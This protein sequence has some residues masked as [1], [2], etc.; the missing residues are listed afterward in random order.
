MANTEIASLSTTLGYQTLGSGLNQHQAS[1]QPY[2]VHPLEI[3][4]HA[5]I[6]GGHLAQT[7]G[8]VALIT[9]CLSKY[10]ELR[11]RCVNSNTITDNV[12]WLLFIF[13]FG[14][15]LIQLMHA[16]VIGNTVAISGKF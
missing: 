5:L 14:M 4:I 1:Q 15:T 8:S 2:S 13:V 16:L 9:L 6:L 3:F 10:S 12:V 11:S 7:L